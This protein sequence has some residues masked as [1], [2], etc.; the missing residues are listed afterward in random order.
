MSGRRLC[1]W[2]EKQLRK[3]SFESFLVHDSEKIFF[4]PGGLKSP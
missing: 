4:H 2:E 3:T 1:S